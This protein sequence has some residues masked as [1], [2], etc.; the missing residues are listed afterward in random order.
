[1][2]LY[3][4]LEL[5]GTGFKRYFRSLWNIADILG[6]ILT[7]ILVAVTFNNKYLLSWKTAFAFLHVIMFG[8][9]LLFLRCF[10]KFRR[11]VKM[12]VESF[13]RMPGFA[14][15]IIFMMLAAVFILKITDESDSNKIL[16]DY[17]QQVF[18]LILGDPNFEHNSSGMVVIKITIMIIAV[19]TVLSL[20]GRN[21]EEVYDEIQQNLISVDSKV[22]AELVLEIVCVFRNFSNLRTSGSQLGLKTY[23]FIGEA[24][25]LVRRS[26]D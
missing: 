14:V 18:E 7:L 16:T 10:K 15:V 11:F 23:L 4:I 1:M 20:Y 26:D 21:Q 24:E 2:I 6:P 25:D 13:K 17:L 3:E 8:R 19:V 9:L 5:R 12:V 22:T